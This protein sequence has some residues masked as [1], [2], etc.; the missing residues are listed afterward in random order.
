MVLS[1]PLV[2]FEMSQIM[3]Y[4]RIL[5]LTATFFVAIF[6]GEFYRQAIVLVGILCFTAA[7]LSNIDRSSGLIGRYI[8]FFISVGAVC[9]GIVRGVIWLADLRRAAL[10][11]G[12]EPNS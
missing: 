5:A 6:L 8:I 12:E 7:I 4:A 1:W 11:E 2:G 10:L 9:I 3:G